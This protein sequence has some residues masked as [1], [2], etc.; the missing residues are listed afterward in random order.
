VTGLARP[1]SANAFALPGGYVYLTRGI[2]AYMD[3]EA[4]LAGV[5]GHEIGHLTARHGAQRATSEQNGGRY[6]QTRADAEA[7]Y[8]QLVARYAAPRL[9]PPFNLAAW[10]AAGFSKAELVDLARKA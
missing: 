8:P 4:D 9:R 5:I 3:S 1:F 10:G 6:N 2:M 7:L